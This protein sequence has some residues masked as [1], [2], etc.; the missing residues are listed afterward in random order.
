[1][2][3]LPRR[4]HVPDIGEVMSYSIEDLSR[5]QGLIPRHPA[6]HQDFSARAAEVAV[7]P[8]R[9]SRRES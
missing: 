3:D 1:M 2:L 4:L 6:H 9:F 5:L 8:A 7:W